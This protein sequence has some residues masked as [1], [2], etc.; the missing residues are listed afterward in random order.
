MLNN[1]KLF[2]IFITKS[3]KIVSFLQDKHQSENMNHN[4][5]HNVWKKP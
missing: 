3:D 4:T 1:S 5:F 2:F